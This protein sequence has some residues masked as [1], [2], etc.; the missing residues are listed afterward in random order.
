LKETGAKLTNVRKVF[1]RNDA[2]LCR[3]EQLEERV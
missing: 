2:V 1:N 3:I